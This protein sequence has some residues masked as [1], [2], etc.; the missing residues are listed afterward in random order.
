[1]ILVFISA[2]AAYGQLQFDGD[3]DSELAP[4]VHSLESSDA[5]GVE[6]ADAESISQTF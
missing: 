5:V 3:E 1:M 6:E 4:A 2:V